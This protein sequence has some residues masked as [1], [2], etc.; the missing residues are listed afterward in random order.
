MRAAAAILFAVPL[1]HAAGTLTVTP[2]TAYV[3]Q[4][5]TQQ[6]T[7]TLNG[8][9]QSAT[10]TASAGSIT[11]A[12]LYKAPAVLPN[13]AT[14]TITAKGSN[15]T[16]TATVTILSNAPPTI[17]SVGSG[18]IPAGVF[19]VTVTGTGFTPVSQATL[20][21]SPRATQ[22]VSPTALTV[23]GFA[24]H[25]GK[26]SLVVSNGSIA[27]QPFPVQVGVPNP[28]VSEG[29]ARRFLQQAAFG[30]TPSEAAHVQQVGFQG[31]LNEQFAMP[32]ISNYQLLMNQSQNGIPQHFLTNAVTQPDQLR[33]K[34]A[35]ALS[36]ILVT[37]IQKSIWN[38][39]V[40]PYQ[41]MLMADAFTN[42]RKILGD[43]TLSPAMGQYLDLANNGKA[44]AAGTV[45]PNENYAREV[46]QLFSIGTWKLNPDGTQVLDALNTGIPTY[47]QKTVSEFA[48]VF[49]GW[50]YQPKTP[51]GAIFWDAYM[52]PVGPLVAYPAEHDTGSKTLLNGAVIPA[53]LSPLADLNAAL[54]NIFNHPN[55]GPF[56]CKQLIQHLVKSNPTPAYVQRVAQVFNNPSNRGDMTSVIAAILL[57]TEARQND[58]GM[59]QSSLDGHLQ[60]PVLF[61][62]GLV[63]AF[64]GIVNDQ[65]YLPWQLSQMNQDIYDAPSVFNF[66]S[67]GY[68]I[69]QSNGV[70]GPEFQIYTPYS[71]IY[72]GTAVASLF[73][74]YS[75]PVLTNGP[76]LT[77]DL[78]PFI[79]LAYFPSTLVDALD[80][81]LTC[82]M[83]PP[84]MKQIVVQAVA[85]ETG[86]SLRRIETGAYL[87]LSSG[88]YNV[89][90]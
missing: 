22:Y 54:D 6:F 60:E 55:V 23:T 16:A 58:S 20:G 89:W 9:A 7:A 10:W 37:S 53:G 62:A 63:R 90:H 15:Q 51:G 74:S 86:P 36:Q 78:T 75:N 31:W 32:Q 38:P 69:P 61:M 19:S 68:V 34:V 79:A 43:V 2:Q 48:R 87:I 77:I 57:D 44:N 59:T 66:Y 42:Y 56:I 1:L 26:P 71:S 4:G 17:S 76:G 64:G 25:S 80:F 14:A 49:T 18:A 8:A 85:A 52:N 67:P 81:T 65:N 3:V 27:S 35:F 70:L 40:I 21:G 29:A 82:G 84:A 46:L 45:L 12:G 73:G 33:Q 39:I 13:P 50:T 41:E 72:R 5:A 11:T 28:M 83:M 30:P 47:D 24:S 88:Y